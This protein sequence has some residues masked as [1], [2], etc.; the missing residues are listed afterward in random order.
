MKIDIDKKNEFVDKFM[1]KYLNN[2]F[3]SMSKR[4]IDVLVMYLLIKYTKLKHENN[5]DLSMKL[6]LTE[7]KVKNLKYEANLKY[8]KKLEEGI[9][10]DFLFLLNNAKLQ[11]IG[12]ETWISIVVEDIFLRNAIKAE[13]KKNGSFTDS[14]FNSEIVKISTYDF[15]YLMYKFSTGYEQKKFEKEIASLVLIEKK[16]KFQELFKIFIEEAVAE[17]SKQS[18]KLGFAYLSAGTSVLDQILNNFLP[19]I[20]EKIS[21]KRLYK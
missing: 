18:V 13:V 10:E 8:S 2:G 16:S 9:K 1:E 11:V 21:W 3:G 5:F 20:E 4:D 12:K 15:S 19:F 6:K 14:S 7:S 17:A